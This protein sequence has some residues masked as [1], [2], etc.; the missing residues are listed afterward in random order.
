MPSA[1]FRVVLSRALLVSAL[2][3]SAAAEPPSIVS[4]TAGSLELAWTP[5]SALRVERVALPPGTRAALAPGAPSGVRLE[6]GGWHRRTR[7]VRLVLEPGAGP[8]RP[9][10]IDFV[11]DE[12]PA[13]ID[14]IAPGEERRP[15]GSITVAELTSDRLFLNADTAR[16][17]EARLRESPELRPRIDLR[18]RAGSLRR[19][20]AAHQSAAGTDGRE[21]W[22]W[23]DPAAPGVEGF[24]TGR[25]LI[26][27][28]LPGVATV[29]R[30]DGAWRVL[31]PDGIYRIS[32]RQLADAGQVIDGV[33]TDELRLTRWANRPDP[34]EVALKVDDANGNGVFDDG[35]AFE[36][37]GEALRG[38]SCESC[39]QKADYTDINGYVLDA[40]VGARLRVPAAR[41]PAGAL[42]DSDDHAR[43]LRFEVGDRFIGPLGLGET[44]LDHYY[45]CG[46]LTWVQ[47]DPSEERRETLEL[48]G[49]RRGSSRGAA[50]RVHLYAKSA[51]DHRSIVDVNGFTFS[52]LES[53]GKLL[54]LHEAALAASDLRND[55]EITITVP[56]TPSGP[57]R[58]VDDF[59]LDWIEVEY[60]AAYTAVNDRLWF[61]HEGGETVTVTGFSATDAF[62]ILDVSDPVNAVPIEATAVTATSISFEAETAG[63][64]AVAAHPAGEGAVSPLRLSWLPASSLRDP[65][66]D[67]DL[68]AIGPR[69]WLFEPG[70]AVR[71]PVQAWADMREAQG[72]SVLPVAIEEVLA[73]FSG[74]VHTPSG[75]FYFLQH[76]LLEWDGPPT[77]AVLIGD[78]STD[79]KGQLEG[80]VLLPSNCM[81]VGEGPPCFFNEPAWFP[82][83]QTVIEDNASDADFVGHYAADARL[84]TVSGPDYIPDYSLGRLPVRSVGELDQLLAKLAA[85][86]ALVDA[87]PSWAARV[88]FAADEMEPGDTRMEDAQEAARLTHVEPHYTAQTYYFQS[89]Y[90]AVDPEA[91]TADL[92]AGW[93]D[94]GAAVLSYVGHGNALNWSDHAL[95]T[96]NG[97]SDCRNDVLDHLSDPS[98]PLPVVLNVGCITGAFMRDV[99]PA[100]L[101]EL[102]RSPGGAIA[103]YGPTGL[104]DLALADTIVDAFMGGIHGPRGRGLLLGEVA[105]GVQTRL[106]ATGFVGEAL[107]NAM[108]GDPSMRL[109]VPFGPPADAIDLTAI[110]GDGVVMLS[111]PAV[112]GADSYAVYR[113][114]VDGPAPPMQV[115]D[116]PSTSFDDSGVVNGTLYEYWLEASAAGRPGRWTDPGVEARPCSSVPPA[117][118]TNLVVSPFVDR[119]VRLDWDVSPTVGL[120][121]YR[122]RIYAGSEASGEPLVVRDVSGNFLIHGTLDACREYTFE[123]RALGWC[124][125]ESPGAATQTTRVE[126]C[127]IAADPPRTVRDL[128]LARS[129]DDL[130]LSWSPVT[131]TLQGAPF[132][133]VRYQVHRS[134]LP[135]FLASA[136]TVATTEP[137]AGSTL[138]GAAA[139]GGPVLEVFSVAAES[140]SGLTGGIGRD[141]PLGVDDLAVA[142]AGTDWDL[143]WSPVTVDLEGERTALLGYQVHA[144]LTDFDAS[145]AGAATLVEVLPPDALSTTVSKGL[146][147][148]HLVLAQDVHG[149]PAPF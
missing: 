35:D 84:A 119:V 140:D 100:L 87:P 26:E 7:F 138:T 86:D 97:G 45:W 120:A 103:G 9:I 133:L 20:A 62:T 77:H 75:T 131:E 125:L 38:E 137:V 59:L 22:P 109:V 44:G 85:Y 6:E 96:N 129:G 135:D 32:W 139:P 110:P 58:P 122:V 136:A 65:S 19:H 89:G 27:V 14:A 107:S 83:V 76:A 24:E 90:G 1:K 10:R 33:P 41:A 53:S 66:N 108:L 50:V 91:Y 95:L 99:G 88:H 144:S 29:D 73:E 130:I 149:N 72:I 67:H 57:D 105:L 81:D 115:G 106:A 34:E 145:D 112:A 148:F 146:G 113:Q 124:E 17:V 69:D 13:V 142:D 80:R 61:D 52:D 126:P 31:D 123:V 118:A 141:F 55:T 121:G 79:Y 56:D 78:T 2:A 4:E 54:E 114:E 134:E 104:T 25:L 36:F 37:W 23:G 5:E 3:G 71:A 60:P 68:L 15:A 132:T 98:T 74:G 49:L 47:G 8:A 111:W 64:Y 46:D 94:P 93:Q 92:I 101:E 70:G 63:R 51:L 127:P 117:P 28:G 48:P 102:V 128:M 16:R 82:G 18:S 143:S 43:T 116:T 40:V 42:P 12:R 21:G 30:G 147:D 11:P 39:Y